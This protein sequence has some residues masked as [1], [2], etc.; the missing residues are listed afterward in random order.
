MGHA[1][2]HPPTAEN[3]LWRD[4][5]LRCAR[6]ACILSKLPVQPF[7]QRSAL[8]D[9][10]TMSGCPIS[11]PYSPVRLAT[12]RA[13]MSGQIF[14]GTSRPSRRWAIVEVFPHAAMVE[15]GIEGMVTVAACSEICENLLISIRETNGPQRR[16]AGEGDLGSLQRAAG[17]G[18]MQI[19]RYA[20]ICVRAT[21]APRC[22]GF[23]INHH[24]PALTRRRDRD[25]PQE[26][27][28]I[29]GDIDA[30]AIRQSVGTV[31]LIGRASTHQGLTVMFGISQYPRP[32]PCQPGTP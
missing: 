1:R 8:I 12:R 28:L 18:R 17:L 3:H 30:D 22:S 2:P 7:D 29:S 21:R 13:P 24:V 31:S 15:G 19:A 14:I 16:S 4:A 23:T 9:G 32:P 6:C 5:L 25:A 26:T 27:R 20:S 11:S 10:P